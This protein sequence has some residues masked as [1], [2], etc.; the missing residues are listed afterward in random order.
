M[1]SG[2]GFDTEI[3][4]QIGGVPGSAEWV[5]PVQ[6]G[7]FLFPEFNYATYDRLAAYLSATSLSTSLSAKTQHF[8][9]NKYSPHAQEVHYT[10]L[11]YPDGEYNV[12]CFVR[13][14]W[15]PAGELTANLSAKINIAGDLYDDWHVAPKG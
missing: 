1:K 5:T 15:T 11:W 7:Q 10:P 9:V 8:K 2:Y 3:K 13:D 4:T 12:Y 6:S 14:A